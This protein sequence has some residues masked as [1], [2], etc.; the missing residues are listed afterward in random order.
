MRLIA[1]LAAVLVAPLALAGCLEARGDVMLNPDGSGK[2]IGDMAFDFGAP[3][4]DSRKKSS[5]TT[6]TPSTKPATTTATPAKAPEPTK[7]PEDELKQ[8]KEAVASIMKKSKGIDVWKDVYYDRLPD[9]R[10]HFKGTAYFKDLSKVHIWPDTGKGAVAFGSEGESLMLVLNRRKEPAAKTTPKTEIAPDDLA[11]KM[12]DERAKWQTAKAP[13]EAMLVDMS[14]RLSFR[15][16]GLPSEVRGLEQSGGALVFSLDGRNLFRAMDNAVGDSNTLREMI[17]NRES[18]A[19]SRT[20]D[21]TVEAQIFGGRGESWAR[22]A[23]PFRVR[24]DYA[25]EVE[26]AKGAYPRMMQRLELEPP[27]PAKTTGTPGATTPK[28]GAAK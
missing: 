2:V 22:L 17:V 18:F 4:I 15:T 12:K 13:V 1:A 11:K 7:T 24:F 27:P 14:L 8:L 10:G 23:P 25:A 19:S 20:L 6:P 26:S 5:S 28:G 21:K 16:P 3:F 9:G